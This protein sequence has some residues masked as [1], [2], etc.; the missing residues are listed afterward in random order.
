[1]SVAFF[2][3]GLIS[4]VGAFMMYWAGLDLS[5][6]QWSAPAIAG[7]AVLSG[8]CF[9]A[10]AIAYAGKLRKDAQKKDQ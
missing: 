8:L 6:F 4:G 5:R 7:F 10:S 3:L 9:V 2:V 1:M